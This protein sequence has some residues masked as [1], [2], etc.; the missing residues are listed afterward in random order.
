MSIKSVCVYCASNH[1]TPEPMRI[2]ARN[3]G[4]GIAEMGLH[5]VYG[6][7]SIGMMGEVAGSALVAGGD[8][9]GIIPEDLMQKEVPPANLTE[10][11]VTENM[12]VRKMTMFNMSDAFVSLPGGIGTLEET[13]EII[14][15]K[16][17]GLHDYPILILNHEGFF[18][19]LLKQ[20]ERCIKDGVML[21]E[22]IRLLHFCDTVDDLLQHLE[23]GRH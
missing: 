17:L 5:L 12:H 6:G 21:E 13:M 4:R 8:V 14:T 11:I 9:T 1:K 20:F 18:D 2:V 23:N 15:W 10:L 22:V 16:Y 3:V 19:H 7:A